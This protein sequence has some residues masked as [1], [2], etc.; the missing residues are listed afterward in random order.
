MELRV[1]T[2]DV[3]ADADVSVY[4]DVGDDEAPVA[5]MVYLTVEGP[6]LC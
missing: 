6:A 5:K 1:I 4:A 3:D 2:I